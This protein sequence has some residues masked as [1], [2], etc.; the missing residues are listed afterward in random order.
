MDAMPFKA[1]LCSKYW[2]YKQVEYECIMNALF[3]GRKKQQQRTKTISERPAPAWSAKSW[4]A[5]V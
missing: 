2:I 3:K 1:T 5:K 4:I